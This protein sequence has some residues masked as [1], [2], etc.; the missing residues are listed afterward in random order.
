MAEFNGQTGIWRTSETGVHYFIPDGVDPKTAWGEWS[1]ERHYL[2]YW[3][4]NEPDKWGLQSFSG[5]T[6]KEY[7][8]LIESGGIGE[9]RNYIDENNWYKKIP[10]N[11][12]E[13][14]A[15]ALNDI[16]DIKNKA[17]FWNQLRD[18]I[19][20]NGIY[21][22]NWQVIRDAFDNEIADKYNKLIEPVMNKINNIDLDNSYEHFENGLKSSTTLS[23][24]FKTKMLQN[25]EN[26]K[27][28]KCK[29]MLAAMTDVFGLEF[30]NSEA[31]K[32][33][34]YCNY[35]G[36]SINILERHNDVDT[37]F[38]EGFHAV[39]ERYNIRESGLKEIM[40]KE[41]NKS[42][43]IDEITGHFLN[44]AAKEQDF[45]NYKS[46]TDKIDESRN[47]VNELYAKVKE[48]FG[49]PITIYNNIEFH[50]M[51]N[52]NEE[53]QKARQNYLDNL[54]YQDLVKR[55][56]KLKLSIY[57]NLCDMISA[58]T[59]NKSEYGYG[60]TGNY[61]GEDKWNQANEFFAEMA[62]MKATG[63][64]EEYELIRKFAPQSVAKFEE[65]FE[66]IFNNKGEP[67]KL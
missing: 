41:L 33:W 4:V 15:N 22:D 67:L 24:S 59:W 20:G 45:E 44:Q 14:M 13:R 49:Q 25:F 8:K 56:A 2:Q 21:A 47:K 5:L 23:K 63:S 55:D 17:D 16:T 3:K 52:R 10:E 26:C 48:D 46:V 58:A 36:T 34:S 51:L 61:W 50:H 12:E 19:W 29:I 43:K 28:E 31:G 42:K 37:L 66:N 1:K 38:H 60:H 35:Q 11:I 6:K 62:S 54:R 32:E 30:T 39:F 9:I 64:K 27:D 65:L 57:P 53:Y 7:D 40:K 18:K